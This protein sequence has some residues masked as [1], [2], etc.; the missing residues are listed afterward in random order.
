[1]NKLQQLVANLPDQA[2]EVSDKS[3]LYQCMDWAYLYIFCLGYP[4]ATIQ[5]LY[6]YEVFTKPTDLTRQYFDII[7]NTADFIPKE[8]DL[9]VFGT[10]VGVAG[11]IVVCN[12]KGDLKTFQSWDQNWNGQSKITLVTHSYGGKN[13]FLGVL[14]PKVILEGCLI[15]SDDAGKT[16]YEHLVDGSAVRKQMAEYLGVDNP[17]YASFDSLVRVVAG[18]KSRVTDLEKQVGFERTERENRDEQ[19]SRMKD[20]L[21]TEQKMR[22][23]LS[24]QLSEALTQPEKLVGVYEGQ[25]KQKQGVIDEQG[26]TIG[27]L[28]HTI[29]DL[30][31]EN[32]SLKEKCTGPLSAYDVA[33]IL[34]KKLI[35]W[36]KSTKLQ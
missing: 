2:V 26:K 22:L 17:D 6:A 9:G 12:G 23:E 35:P 11:H 1:M 25:L 32:K 14:R 10:E 3:N 4:K 33:V 21:L 19:V 16:L 8:G 20:Q 7:P 29:T 36:L 34:L 15:G 24:S 30:E 13:G 27:G 18:V 31:I 28:Q 5:H